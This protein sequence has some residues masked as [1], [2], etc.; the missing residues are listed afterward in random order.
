M[1]IRHILDFFILFNYLFIYLF[2]LFFFFW[3]GGGGRV[4]KKKIYKYILNWPLLFTI[5][6]KASVT[7]SLYSTCS[8]INVE[9]Y[10]FYNIW[11]VV[12]N[13]SF[14]LREPSSK[15]ITSLLQ[16]MFF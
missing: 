10:I 4:W 9:I 11:I 16:S 15:C 2:I 6:L 13:L 8:L 7:F 1:A 14:L 3:G 12:V 5:F